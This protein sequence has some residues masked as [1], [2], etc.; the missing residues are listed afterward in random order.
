MPNKTPRERGLE[1]L[2]EL[3]PDQA[4][5]DAQLAVIGEAG[6][7]RLGQ[8]TLR[9]DEFSRQMDVLT[10]QR[11]ETDGYRSTLD[12]WWEEN[13]ARLAELDRLAA[14]NAAL[15][16]GRPSPTPN[17]SSDPAAPKY[18]TEEQFRAE[19]E[20]T[21]RGAVAFFRDLNTLSM[22]H[23]QQFGELLDTDAILNDRRV[24]QIGLV[25]V[26]QD[27]HKDQLAARAKAADEARLDAARK[28]GEEKA[29]RE[30]TANALPYPVSGHE[31]STLDGVKPNQA[32]QAAT[33]DDMVAEYSRLEQARRAS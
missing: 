31:P 16:A 30:L 8:A 23:F 20:K 5:R 33:V 24:Q 12:Q 22:R 6:L 14:E 10:T 15:K 25:G 28:E 7:D 1:V 13:Q 29:R 11:R 2:V 3:Y 9:Q 21:E 4:V 18:L 32:P 19:L 26:Y 27:L 17:P